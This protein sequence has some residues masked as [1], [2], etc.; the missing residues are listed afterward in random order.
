M[1]VAVFENNSRSKQKHTGKPSPVFFRTAQETLGVSGSEALVV[2]DDIFT[3][4]A[5][6]RDAGLR[7]V[8]VHTGKGSIQRSPSQINPEHEVTSIAG[9]PGLF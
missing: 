3:D 1:T 4:I 7:S 9:L 5:G 8:L 2:G 6:A